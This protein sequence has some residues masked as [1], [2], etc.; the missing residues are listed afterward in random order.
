MPLG[1][2]GSTP[3]AGRGDGK[4]YSGSIVFGIVGLDVVGRIYCCWCDWPT[5]CNNTMHLHETGDEHDWAC[6]L[7]FSLNQEG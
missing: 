5:A 2:K 6:L 3:P 4:N 1:E 7:D